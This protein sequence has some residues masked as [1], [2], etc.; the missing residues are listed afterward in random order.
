MNDDGLKTWWGK[1]DEKKKE[2]RRKGETLTKME[3]NN[4]E[5]TKECGSWKNVLEK[6]EKQRKR[7]V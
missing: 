3:R 5:S 7:V 2:N 4:M 1:L 6:S